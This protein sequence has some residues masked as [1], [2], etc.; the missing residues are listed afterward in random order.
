[1][2]KLLL[3]LSL[4]WI[5]I[6]FTS[7]LRIDIVKVPTHENKIACLRVTN[8]ENTS[9]KGGIY[10][11]LRKSNGDYT[12][13]KSFVFTVIEKPLNVCLT[14]ENFH[15]R[16]SIVAKIKSLDKKIK[17]QVDDSIEY[18]YS[19]RYKSYL[20]LTCG[21]KVFADGMIDEIHAIT[22]EKTIVLE[23]G[24]NLKR[25]EVE[26]LEVHYLDGI[27]IGSEV[28]IKESGKILKV[29]FITE[30]GHF[31]LEDNL[32]VERT[33]IEKVVCSLPNCQ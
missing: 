19:P 8:L 17:E 25:H 9:R 30:K 18:S 13:S 2:K 12:T 1:M 16:G 4:L 10:L 3:P 22:A 7:E 28:L 6:G 23:N 27:N 20:P 32:I 14:I 21:Q 26:S 31:V 33:H 15:E 24:K 11:D 5:N 29:L